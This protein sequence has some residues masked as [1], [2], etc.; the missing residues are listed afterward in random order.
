MDL[1]PQKSITLLNIQSVKSNTGLN[2]TKGAPV[3]VDWDSGVAL[4]SAVTAAS[5]AH[6][7]W[8]GTDKADSQFV[9]KIPVIVDGGYPFFTDQYNT[10][11][12]FALGDP[13]TAKSGKWD[14]AGSGDPVVGYVVKTPGTDS[15]L[16]FFYHG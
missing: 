3:F 16:G 14:L 8:Y 7:V 13:I 1:G 10:G 5:K 12:T 15:V 4:A 6:P 9:G 2:V 11:S